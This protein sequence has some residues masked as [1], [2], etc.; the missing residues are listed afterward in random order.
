[1]PALRTIGALTALI[2]E[3]EITAGPDVVLNAKVPPPPTV[4]PTDPMNVSKPSAW[5]EASTAD[6]VVPGAPKIAI[7]PAPSATVPVVP[8]PDVQFAPF[9][10]DELE[11][12]LQT[13]V[14]GAIEMS[15]TR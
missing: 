7:W 1:M 13:S 5:L 11:V 6:P 8:L 9:S 2:P 3:A 12:L 15:L 4:V 14:L 10:Q